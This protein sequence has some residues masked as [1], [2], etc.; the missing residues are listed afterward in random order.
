MKLSR[1]PT[2]AV[3]F[4]LG[5]VAMSAAA[6]A[7][8]AVGVTA[9]VKDGPTSADVDTGALQANGGKIVITIFNETGKVWHDVTIS[10]NGKD[11]GD[12]GT[13]AIG[14]SSLTNGAHT[15]DGDGPQNCTEGGGQFVHFAPGD[16]SNQFGPPCPGG[17]ATLTCVLTGCDAAGNSTNVVTVTYSASIASAESSGYGTFTLSWATDQIRKANP[18]TWHAQV[19]GRVVNDD[20]RKNLI[21][22]DGVM[23][24]RAESNLSVQSV[25][26]RE[27]TTGYPLVSGATATVIDGT[28][29]E[30]SGFSLAPEQDV[31]VMVHF[32]G[33][34]SGDLT[35]MLL[36]A[37]FD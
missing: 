28:T 7:D 1:L 35:K 22:L 25:S 20:G 24:F 33:A 30:I 14:D 13:P 10:F 2:A 8:T 32:S 27:N 26:L 23:S 12:A 6:R 18:D 15:A 36:T 34:A 16:A 5:I 29:F 9:R 3:A 31:L 19:V 37:T 4:M 21:Q 11:S 17:A